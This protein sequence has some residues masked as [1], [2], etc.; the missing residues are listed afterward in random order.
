MRTLG[1]ILRPRAVRINA[2]PY[3]GVRSVNANAV[4]P[5]ATLARNQKST[6]QNMQHIPIHP[7]PAQSGSELATTDIQAT[8]SIVYPGR[9]ALMK[10]LTF[11]TTTLLCARLGAQATDS[12]D[13]RHRAQGG[14]PAQS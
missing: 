10:C 4:Q 12:S 5:N 2:D 13:E 14:A 9:R 8:N 1:N 6:L 11:A 7:G 3:K